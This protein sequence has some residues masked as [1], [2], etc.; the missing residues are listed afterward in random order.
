[1]FAAC[2]RQAARGRE[3]FRISA[4]L[5][6]KKLLATV[7]HAIPN[8]QINEGHN[9]APHI[10]N[11][12]LP[13]RDTDYLVTLLDEAG[14][15]V[16]TRSACET[17]SDAGSRAVLALTGDANRAESTLRVS[18]GPDTKKGALNRFVNALIPAVLF[19]DNERG[20]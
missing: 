15:A 17:D 2:L 7:T 16:S 1:M 5:I 4:E 10:L 3:E 13:G 19:V 8:V 11:L 9:Q 18:W 12:S 14:F 6:R 20:R